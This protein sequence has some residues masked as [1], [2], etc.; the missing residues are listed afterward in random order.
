MKLIQRILKTIWLVI[1]W[2]VGI[3]A[4]LVG[5]ALCLAFILAVLSAF[6]NALLDLTGH[7]FH[8]GFWTQAV[9]GA[10]T[11][12]GVVTT[13]LAGVNLGL[14][15]REK[16]DEAGALNNNQPKNPDAHTPDTH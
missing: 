2:P 8:A 10:A 9:V 11:I 16:W 12:I 14:F 7:S 3:L 15:I 13:L 1:R 6:G 4:V 5:L